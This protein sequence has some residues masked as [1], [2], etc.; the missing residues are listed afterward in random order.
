MATQCQNTTRH[1]RA[2]AF[3]L[4]CAFALALSPAA[5]FART[6]EDAV[7]S[8]AATS[9]ELLATDEEEVAAE[10]N[11]DTNAPED[12]TLAPAPTEGDESDAIQESQEDLSPAPTTPE[13]PA[14]DETAS[15]TPEDEAPEASSFASETTEVDGLAT[16]EPATEP[17][18]EVIPE[19]EPAQADPTSSADPEP[20][21]APSPT[22]LTAQATS[23]LPSAPSGATTK[24]VTNGRT[25]VIQSLVATTRVVAAESA[26]ATSGTNIV[27]GAYK[28]SNSQKWVVKREGNS[29]WYRLLLAGSDGKLALGVSGSNVCVVKNP[30]GTTKLLNVLWSFVSTGSGTYRLVNASATSKALDVTDSSTK[31]GTNLRLAAANTSKPANQSFRMVDADPTVA[32]GTK[33]LTGAYTVASSAKTNLIAGTKSASRAVNAPL[34]LQ[35]SD[36]TR[37][38]HVY[39]QPDGKGYYI[40]WVVGSG[41]VLT[42][43]GA[44]ILPGTKLVQRVWQGAEHQ[45]WAVVATKNADGTY[46]ATLQNK[47][48]GLFLGAASA[49]A[50]AAVTGQ[51]KGDANTK[52]TLTKQGLLKAGITC[53]TPLSTAKTALSIPGAKTGTSKVVLWTNSGAINQRFELQSVGTNL[54][55]IRTASSGGWLTWKSGSIVRQ[56]GSSASAKSKANTWKAVWKNGGISL[57][58][59]ESGKALQM[60]YGKTA[61]GTTIVAYKNKG[62]KAQHFVCTPAPLITDGVYLVNSKWEGRR[63]RVDGSSEVPANISNPTYGSTVAASEKFKITPVGSAYKI[64]N[65]KSGLVMTGGGYADKDGYANVSQKRNT[66]AQNQLWKAQIGDGGYVEF[67]NAASGKY[68]VSRNNNSKTSDGV[69][70]GFNVVERDAK[71]KSTY[72]TGCSWKLKATTGTVKTDPVRGTT[73]LLIGNS[74]TLR[75]KSK[76]V[77]IDKQLPTV[78]KSKLGSSAYVDQAALEGK[79]LAHHLNTTAADA[80]VAELARQT[81]RK[82]YFGD[83]DAIVIQEKTSVPLDEYS[84]YLTNLKLFVNLSKKV[85][86]TPIIYSTWAYAGGSGGANEREMTVAQMHNALQSKFTSAFQATGATIANVGAAFKDKGFASSLYDTDSKHPSEAGCALAASVISATVK[87]MLA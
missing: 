8:A 34:T 37:T 80:E 79:S 30:T 26:K 53:I 60:S 17:D 65:V 56:M 83:W 72:L 27:S 11:T 81:M 33:G 73:V 47:G 50:G 15:T 25:Y 21:A 84:S 55:R 5:A 66:G 49:T 63:L 41:R 4:A 39:L 42:V 70:P 16:A 19:P 68:L 74:F 40:A 36:G 71:Q 67:V 46:T 44:S 1:L 58:N 6:E 32:T 14:A 22:P 86:A 23:S 35:V 62:S 2:R 87:M 82:I 12:V 76:T 18:Q 54:W 52:L 45:R 59:L 13:A 38:Q 20:K 75:T 29:L 48:T 64:T 85:K 31:A 69:W 10:I 3:A 78:L 43:A 51:A 57:V 28:G 9:E 77:P 24:A 7:A 61:K